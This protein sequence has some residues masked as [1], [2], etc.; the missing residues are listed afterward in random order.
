[1]N[2]I[3]FLLI[4][5]LTVIS[6]NQAAFSQQGSIEIADNAPDQ[7]TVVK[8]DTL[9]SIAARFIKQPWRWPEVW[10]MNEAQIRN[11]HLIYPGQVI[12][13]DRRG[14]YLTVGRKFGD[15]G[16]LRPTVYSESLGDAVHSIPLHVIAP[17]LVH[18]LV[19]EENNWPDAGTIVATDGR[20]LQI[21]PG[22]VFFAKDIKSDVRYWDVFEPAKL[23]EH[24]RTKEKLGY[25]LDYVGM[26]KLKQM[27]EGDQVSTFE[28]MESNRDIYT[29]YRLLPRK[30]PDI[31]AFVPHAP[32]QKVDGTIIK[33]HRGVLETGR[34]HVIVLD[35]GVNDGLEPGHVLALDRHLGKVSYRPEGSQT[36]AE[37]Y[38]LP[39][40]RYGLAFVFKV[41]DKVSYALVME[42]NKSVTVGDSVRTP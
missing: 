7:Y 31:F 9:W 22:E 29:G 39:D 25:E 27:G 10:R 4:L 12:M 6:V 30:D 37:E 35:L 40:Q 19:S 16:K 14:P 3:I 24:P 32:E 23:L 15:D 13:L 26:A 5:C 42:T 34:N 33:M 1:M 2:R 8:G 20:K 21:V 28:M 41:F 17:F 11:P 18:P 36:F 38:E